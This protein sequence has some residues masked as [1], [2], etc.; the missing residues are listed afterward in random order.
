ML[1]KRKMDNVKKM[2][3]D[4][5]ESSESASSQQEDRNLRNVLDERTCASWIFNQNFRGFPSK[6]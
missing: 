6:W 3:K 1:Y 5:L 2:S 4:E